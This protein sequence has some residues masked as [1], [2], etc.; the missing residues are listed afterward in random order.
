MDTITQTLPRV[1]TKELDNLDLNKRQEMLARYLRI[2]PFALNNITAVI[3]N[4][5]EATIRRDKRAIVDAGI[6]W[7]NNLATGGF[8][9]ECANKLSIMEEIIQDDYAI[10][11]RQ[12]QEAK[13]GKRHISIPL[14][15][16]L[17][18]E[19]KE[20]LETINDVPLYHKYMQWEIKMKNEGLG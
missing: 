17:F 1:E 14:K 2:N 10:F 18:R 8:M 4:V 15:V 13:G 12:Q 19:V 5:S 9:V 7:G 20:K 11:K 3:F 6:D 16:R